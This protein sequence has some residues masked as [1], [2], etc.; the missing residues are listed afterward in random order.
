[1]KKRTSFPEIDL[2]DELDAKQ[3]A[4]SYRK[5]MKRKTLKIYFQAT[6]EESAK[7][8]D[9]ADMGEWDEIECDDVEDA[10][11]VIKYEY[12]HVEP[13]DSDF[14][15]EVWYSTTSP[16]QDH[17]YFTKG[18]EK[19]Y[20]IH[21]KGFSESEQEEIFHG[22]GFGKKKSNPYSKSSGKKIIWFKVD[23]PFGKFRIYFKEARPHQWSERGTT[24]K[25]LATLAGKIAREE[26]GGG[27]ARIKGPSEVASEIPKNAFESKGITRA[28]IQKV[29]EDDQDDELP[30]P[31][32]EEMMRSNPY[33]NELDNDPY[34][35]KKYTEA[36]AYL[37]KHPSK[38]EDKLLGDARN[39]VHD[40][41]L[42]NVAM[43]TEYGPVRDYA[44]AKLV[45]FEKNLKSNPLRKGKSRK[46]VSS[47]IRELM[48]SGRPQ[49]QAVAIALKKA[50][51]SRKSNPERQINFNNYRD[52]L[53]SDD[54]EQ[55]VDVVCDHC[56]AKTYNDVRDTLKR[57]SSLIPHFGIFERLIKENGKWRYVA[58]Q[59]YP[60]EIRNVRELILKKGRK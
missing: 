14:H 13:S 26:L 44:E 50:G 37:V 5:N 40:L 27:A 25:D 41:M 22:L 55:I 8:G 58:G 30:P 34:V 39:A 3:A 47:N 56:R 19:Y 45:L 57:M 53:T 59:S 33:R 42:V 31:I 20:T 46:V 29:P 16:V 23:S 38:R 18:V 11:K 48:H 10:I 7:Q 1:M 49:K 17:D 43:S 15:K 6:T 60:D 4:E 35:K 52:H 36:K 9:F 51:L 2:E 54:V 32:T 21:P 12:G 28:W 24:D